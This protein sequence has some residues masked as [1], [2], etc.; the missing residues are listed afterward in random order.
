MLEWWC[1]LLFWWWRLWLGLLLLG[2][3]YALRPALRSLLW[4]RLWVFL[5]EGE[6]GGLV[7]VLDELSRSLL[8]FLC[9]SYYL[10]ENLFSLPMMCNLAHR[11]KMSHERLGNSHPLL[12]GFYVVSLF[13][14]CVYCLYPHLFVFVTDL[15]ARSYVRDVCLSE[16]II[17]NHI[18]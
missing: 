12:V 4:W 18:N 17:Y 9:L 11:D 15:R 6:N 13:I 10:R 1:L 7:R 3:A 2:R 5:D 16:R 8:L 14:W